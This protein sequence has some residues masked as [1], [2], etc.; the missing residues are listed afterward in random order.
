MDPNQLQP[1]GEMSQMPMMQMPQGMPMPEQQQVSRE[2]PM[3]AQP[4]MET[5]LEPLEHKPMQDFQPLPEWNRPTSQTGDKNNGQKKQLLQ[6]LMN[7]LLNKP[8]RSMHE[9]INGVKVAIGAYKNYAKEWDSLNGISSEG[10]SNS[11]STAPSGGSGSDIQKILQGIQAKKIPKDGGGGPGMAVSQNQ[12]MPPL[13]PAN[14][15]ASVDG[16]YKMPPPVNSLGIW[17]F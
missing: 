5:T 10:M 1:G 7:N 11:V 16:V 4:S 17:G 6:K 2:I 3:S 12:Q 9:L 13:P 8:G 15:P 14:V